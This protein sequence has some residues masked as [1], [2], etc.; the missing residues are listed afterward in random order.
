VPISLLKFQHNLGKSKL[1]STVRHIGLVLATFA[2]KVSGQNAYPSVRTLQSR[3][4]RSRPTIIAALRHL[5]AEG[6]INIQEAQ[7]RGRGWRHRRY[8]L[9]VPVSLRGKPT[10]PRRG[11]HTLYKQNNLLLNQ[12]RGDK[13][14]SKPTQT[15]TSSAASHWCNVLDAIRRVGRY[16]TPD[17]PTEVMDAIRR[18]GGWGSLCGAMEVDLRPGG[19][20]FQKFK[21]AL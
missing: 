16:R 9:D 1:S 10:L 15:G 12:Q 2:D 6:W 13:S 14:P 4:G 3:S 5:Q 20:T 21:A 8:S 19:P 17:L 7:G 18:I 11:G